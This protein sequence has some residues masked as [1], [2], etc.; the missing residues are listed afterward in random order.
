MNFGEALD[1]LKAGKKLRRAGWNGKGMFVFPIL[2]QA[3]SY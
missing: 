3:I 1:A 2:C